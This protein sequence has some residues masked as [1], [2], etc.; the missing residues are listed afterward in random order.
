MSK[1]LAFFTGDSFP[2]KIPC[3]VGESDVVLVQKLSPL[4]FRRNGCRV[5]VFICLPHSKRDRK[6]SCI[7]WR[8]SI[9]FYPSHHVFCHQFPRAS[10]HGKHKQAHAAARTPT[11]PTHCAVTYLLLIPVRFRQIHPVI[12]KIVVVEKGVES[13]DC[14]DIWV[15]PV[16][17]DQGDS[18]G[19]LT[20]SM[21]SQARARHQSVRAKVV[22]RS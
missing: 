10:L 4:L 6:A 22:A 9:A 7:K 16:P 3:F 1:E 12:G 2:G 17:R 18:N 15:G 20:C 21:H 14:V 5:S 19:V 11:A 13:S 8:S